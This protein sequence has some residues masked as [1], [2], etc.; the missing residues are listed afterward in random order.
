MNLAEL[1]ELCRVQLGLPDTGAKGRARINDMLNQALRYV[2][3]DLP[4][5]L[6]RRQYKMKLEK[7]WT[8]GTLSTVANDPYL[9]EIIGSGWSLFSPAPDAV[10]VRARTLEVTLGGD[11]YYTVKI[12]DFFSV[13]ELVGPIRFFF[14]LPAPYPNTGETGLVY[15]VY[16]DAYPIP[17]QATDIQTVQLSVTSQITPFA[18]PESHSGLLMLRRTRGWRASGRVQAFADGDAEQLLNPRQAPKAEV[19]EEPD[20][21][22]RWGYDSGG[23]E[24]G[25]A[26]VGHQ[27]GPAGSFEYCYCLGWGRRP[28]PQDVHAGTIGLASSALGAPGEMRIGLPFFLSGPSKGTGVIATTWGGAA[29]RLISAN[30]HYVYGYNARSDALSRGH[31]GLEKWWFRRRTVALSAGG[32]FPQIEADGVWYLWR[33][34]DA[35]EITTW[36]RGDSDPVDRAFE[37]PRNYGHRE[38]RFDITDPTIEDVLIEYQMKP[39]RMEVDED[40]CPIPETHADI[41][42]EG[43][44]AQMAMRDGDKQGVALASQRQR[45]R[46]QDLI[47][48]YQRDS[49]MA[50]A[51]GRVTVGSGREG[52]WPWPNPPVVG[53]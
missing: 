15:R 21:T 18:R 17:L 53:L 29:V 13:A 33:V 43:V 9:L 10:Q 46:L 37:L 39:G 31:S 7:A 52:I 47:N 45:E 49:F 42:L 1:R 34:T 40:V 28:F 32:A 19:V 26:Y 48:R 12:Q 30:M 14:V 8:R 51:F 2:G 50:A 11:S 16:T 4:E 41:L 38:I 22:E 5:A 6:M 35:K 44:R 3:P 23:T 27:Y 25:V 24:R 36:D 20:P